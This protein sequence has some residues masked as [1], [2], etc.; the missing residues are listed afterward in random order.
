MLSAN[1]P[2]ACAARRSMAPF[3]LSFVLVGCVGNGPTGRSDTEG[4]SL[5]RVRRQATAGCADTSVTYLVDFSS[6]VVDPAASSLV[7]RLTVG[8]RAP[9]GLVG[10]GCGW[11]VSDSEW[12]S[13]NTGVAA[14]VPNRLFTFTGVVSANGPGDSVVSVQFKAHD[15]RDYRTTLAYC[16]VPSDASGYCPNPRQ[17]DVLRVVPR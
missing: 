9:V 11:S 4:M 8:E 5:P 13:S 10:T 3:V 12:S 6:Y 2:N 7:A 1:H 15:G 17:I 14:V 16:S